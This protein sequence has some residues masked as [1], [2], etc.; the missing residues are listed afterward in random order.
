M[1]IEVWWEMH[2]RLQFNLNGYTGTLYY[3]YDT[4]KLVVISKVKQTTEKNDFD[5]NSL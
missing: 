1:H 4:S 3:F 2:I 5:L